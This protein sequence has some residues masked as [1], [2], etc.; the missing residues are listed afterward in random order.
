MSSLKSTKRK[1]D[2]SSEV[3]H[4]QAITSDCTLFDLPNE[5]QYQILC[6]LRFEDLCNFRLSSR[7]SCSAVTCSESSLMHHWIK[8]KLGAPTSTLYPPPFQP[9]LRVLLR[10]MRRWRVAFDVATILADHVEVEILRYTTTRRHRMFEPVWMELRMDMTPLLFSLGH[11]LDCYR[12]LLL[13]ISDRAALLAPSLEDE[14]DIAAAERAIFDKYP[15]SAL[16]TI[17]QMACF[18]TRTFWQ[19]LRPPTYA[20]KTERTVRGWADPPPKHCDLVKVLVLGGVPAVKDILR[21]RSYKKRCKA[22]DVFISTLDPAQSVRWAEN[23]PKLDLD[24]QDVPSAQDASAILRDETFG[25]DFWFPMAKTVLLEKGIARSEADIGTTMDFLNSLAG[26]DMLHRPPPASYA[27][28]HGG[29]AGAF[30]E[31]EQGQNGLA[32]TPDHNSSPEATQ[33]SLWDV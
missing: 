18:L 13:D 7:A 11:Y 32:V 1:Q 14:N 28:T 9:C 22:V 26:Y 19:S 23:W 8:R 30:E 25:H 20:G 15:S 12:S 24:Q 21:L 6:E 2:S 3:A 27:R 10:V 17:H 31:E 16:L 4:D 5:L 33:R 29:Y